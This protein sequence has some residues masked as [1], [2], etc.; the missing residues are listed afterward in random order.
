M[1][2]SHTITENAINVVCTYI[3]VNVCTIF[4]IVCNVI[5]NNNGE[6]SVMC[7]VVIITLTIEIHLPFGMNWAKK[8]NNIGYAKARQVLG[9]I[10][11]N[12]NLWL[13]FPAAE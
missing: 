2:H 5:R 3:H 13:I 6:W 10:E 4:R 11:Q 8:K 12:K 1:T 7:D 9:T